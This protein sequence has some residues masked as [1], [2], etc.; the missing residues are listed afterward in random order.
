M[1][2]VKKSL[3]KRLNYCLKSTLNYIFEFLMKSVHTQVIICLVFCISMQNEILAQDT[4]QNRA[5]KRYQE[6]WKQEEKREAY[7]KEKNEALKLFQ[8]KEYRLAVDKFVDAMKIYPND[9]YCISRIRDI[10][11]ILA[12]YNQDEVLVNAEQIN[13]ISIGDNVENADTVSFAKVVETDNYPPIN[14]ESDKPEE[15]VIVKIVT[16]EDEV[17]PEVQ[18]SPEA[19]NQEIPQISQ[20]YAKRSEVNTDVPKPKS[21]VIDKTSNEFREELAKKYKQGITEENYLD[22]SRKV[23]KRVL[24]RGQKGDEYLRITHHWGGVYYFKNGESINEQSWVS[25]TENL[26]F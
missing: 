18:P 10:E 14:E 5:S 3:Y 22:G 6:H 15:E 25:E 26:K 19:Q 8:K 9:Q 7:E 4:K 11:I 16:K 12:T 2:A 1:S 17:K 20:Q 13:I 24:V 23:T 21:T